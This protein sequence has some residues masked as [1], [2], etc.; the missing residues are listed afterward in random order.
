MPATLTRT[1]AGFIAGVLATLIF[2]QGAYFIMKQFGMPLPGQP[3]NMAPAA[4]A[5]GLPS[6]VNLMF[7]SGLW[8]ILFAVLYDRI[9]GGQ[10]WLKGVVFG[11]VFPMLLGS[12]LIVAL[13]KGQPIL[14]GLLT[15]GNVM[16]LRNGFLLNGLAFGVGLGLLYPWLA[17]M[18][19]AATADRHR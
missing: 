11:C 7:W 12:W 5:Y 8:G 4:Q 2:H 15:D 3:W 14:A 1:I 13:L 9:P 6:L 17:G 10:G 18:L 19:G 16:R